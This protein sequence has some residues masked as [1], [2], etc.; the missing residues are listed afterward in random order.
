[1]KKK[2]P[3]LQSDEEA[4]EFVANADLA[5]YD[6]SDLRTVLF[7]I[8]AENRAYKYAL[9]EAAARSRQGVGN[10]GW[11]TLSTFH[12]ASARSGRQKPG[13]VKLAPPFRLKAGQL[14][15]GF[16]ARIGLRQKHELADRP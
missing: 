16:L 6:L 2:L 9:A 10:K 7:R 11:G 1:M 3:R 8:P 12:S 14:T 13:P 15:A 4:E 5:D